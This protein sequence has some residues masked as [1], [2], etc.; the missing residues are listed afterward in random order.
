MSLLP[1]N[2]SNAVFAVIFFLRCENF[3]DNKIA[4]PASNI[5]GAMKN[6]LIFEIFLI[7]P[8]PPEGALDYISR[9]PSGGQGDLRILIAS[10]RLR[11]IWVIIKIIVFVIIL[12]I[13]FDRNRVIL[14]Y[15]R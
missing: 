14:V 8:C 13:L 1:A 12:I 9:A 11:Y 10:F 5:R 7:T 15:Y 2:Y 3:S 6:F 4:V